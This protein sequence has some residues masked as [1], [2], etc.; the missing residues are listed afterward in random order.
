MALFQFSDLGL[1]CANKACCLVWFFLHL[2]VTSCNVTMSPFK[3]AAVKGENNKGKDHVI[4]V[5]DLSPRLKSNR[6]SLGVYD[7]NKFRTYAA[8]QT[9]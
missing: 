4:N 1:P 7:P 2:F 6:S 9:H 8:F 3:R 5:E